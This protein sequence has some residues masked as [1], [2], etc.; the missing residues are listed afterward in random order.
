MNY[1]FK[2]KYE[3][4]VHHSK[5]FNKI[6][7]ESTIDLMNHFLNNENQVQVDNEGR[8]KMFYV[9]AHN[10]HDNHHATGTHGAQHFDVEA[11]D[12]DE[13]SLQECNVIGSIFQQRME[14][15]KSGDLK[16]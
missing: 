9:L 14:I 11:E 16:P 12:K 5:L 3:I 7:K 4:D 15:R 1:S 2:A 8:V 10:H 6:Y 13:E